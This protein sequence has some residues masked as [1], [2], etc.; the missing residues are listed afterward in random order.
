V[1]SAIAVT[2][3]W[4][5]IHSESF[6][7]EIS[8][9][10]SVMLTKKMGAELAFKRVE[11]GL[12][13]P[14]T[15]F[16]EVSLIKTH[17]QRFGAK[18]AIDELGVYFTYAS[19]IS[20]NL[21]IDEL[22]LKNGS[23]NVEIDEDPTT[24][25]IN[26][27]KLNQQEL[28]E[29]Y[30]H[31]YSQLPLHLNILKLTDVVTKINNVSFNAKSVMISPY[32]KEIRL[33][34]DI[35]KFHLD[36]PATDVSS[37][38]VL[39][40]F[41]KTTWNIDNLLISDLENNLNLSGN[42]T[43][44]SKSLEVNAEGE[45]AIQLESL[46]KY[47]I[48]IP[49]DAKDVQGR[50]SGKFL[51]Q[52]SLFDPNANIEMTI[53]NLKSQ[54]VNLE[55]V[56]VSLQ[57]KKDLILIKQAE[58][59]NKQEHYKTKDAGVVFDLRKKTI[60]NFKIP[61]EVVNAETNTFLF[62]IRD[63]L[64]TFKG[65]VTGKVNVLWD[66]R[67]I[68]FEILEKTVLK[69]FAL[70]MNNS[71]KDILVNNGFIIEGG[72]ITI[73]KNST[74][75]LDLNLTMPLSTLHAKGKIY[76]DRLDIEV[77]NSII[78]MKNFGP[79]SGVK[80]E[81]TG[82]VDLKIQGPMDDVHF[83]FDVKW[84]NFSVIDLHLG[85]VSAHF[86]FGLKNL[87][88]SIPKFEG[89]FNQ[90]KYSANGGLDF[91]D[92]SNMDL[93]LDFKETNFK[94]T[95]QMYALI[96][97]NMKNFPET[98][99]KF[100]TSYR[101]TGGFDLPAL[102][103]N[104]KIKGRDLKIFEEEAD[105]VN[106]DFSLKKEILK[107]EK[108]RIQKSRGEA[109]GNFTVNL[110]NNHMDLIGDGHGIKLSDF[111]HYRQTGL[112]YDADLIFDFNGS[113]TAEKFPSQ[114]KIKTTEAFID[115]MV[116]SPSKAQV[117][118]ENN[119]IITKLDALGSKVKSDI[120]VGMESKQVNIKTSVDSQDLRELLGVLSSHNMLDK[121][122][123][124]KLKAK[125]QAEFN[126][127]TSKLNRLVIDINNFSL[128]KG[129][130]DLKSIT[131]KSYASIENG[132][133]KKWDLRF[134][135]GED[136]FNS[137]GENIRPGL[138]TLSQEFSIKSNIFQLV[139]KFVDKASG[140]IKGN[141]KVDIGSDLKIS[142]FNLNARNNSLKF[143]KMPGIIN[144]FEFEIKKEQQA[145]V[146]KKIQGKYGDGE[147]K[148]L[149]NIL[150]Q[151]IFPQI[152]LE[153]KIDRST[154]PLFKR[155]SVL[156]SGSGTL[157]GV[158]PPY[159]LNGKF[160]LLHGEFLDD[161][162]E[163]SG[164][165]KVNLEEFKKYLP[166]K[167]S[168]ENRGFIALN[169][170][171][172]TANSPLLVK[173]NMAEIYLKG[174]GVVTGN[175]LDPEVNGRVDA[176]PTISKFK[177]KGHEFIINQGFV[178]LKDTGKVRNSDLKFV[179]ISRISDYDMKIDLS[180]SIE[181]LNIN[182]SSEPALAQEDLLSLLTLGVTSDM[183]KNLESGERKYVTTV[184]IGTLLVDQLKINEDLNSSLGLKLSVM[185]EFREDVTSL[186][187]GKSAVTDSSATKLKSSTKIK[188][189]K[190]ISKQVDVS[191]SSTVGGSLEQKQEVNVNYNFN[192]NWSLEGVY[193]VKPAEDTSTSTSTPNSVG[194]DL[195]YKWSF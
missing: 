95:Q 168:E 141:Y 151:G 140:K 27:K 28:Y 93:K 176:L 73:D 97:R 131:G 92:K 125:F 167:N 191:L 147:F 32:K 126:Y 115:N 44:P 24:P 104:G 192:K 105:F 48:E 114:V 173:N 159:M 17:T 94:D 122:L 194:A 81:G 69:N 65:T 153:Y 42:I 18:M 117:N 108:I 127:G 135:D 171:L 57:K 138:V 100:E 124:G 182:L 120:I 155:S 172:E 74:V 29:K 110:N 193:E 183:S 30:S 145:F 128:K 170:N 1:L 160:Q 175:P 116:A 41:E 174:A 86:D 144:D 179:G 142:E 77:A 181:K 34:L 89:Q 22:E 99:L 143:K 9:R 7:R 112:D 119:E 165:K 148:I 137:V 21:E 75:G 76:S 39:A 10:A 152:N 6:S 84:K 19:L 12:F 53:A 111:N 66:G 102:V 154:V 47:Y 78:D 2:A 60:L 85:D 70:K 178:E 26:W 101:V 45:Y 158:K 169:I 68:S 54:W 20:S 189:N 132:N 36:K 83:A 163:Y 11:F 187:Q 96:F 37:I 35:S 64:E 90:T 118:F 149:G 190:Q 71:K 15:R 133:I 50:L 51:V 150:F 58:A 63:V 177:F 103:I 46:S 109:N 62:I 43:T 113:G 31:I 156:A 52:G 13:P 79:I 164:D 121:N 67:N 38:K 180:G 139:S 162:S 56:K 14:S 5:F 186:V 61:V 166:E 136:F 188:V 80:L 55:S 59:F 123:L 33:K 107:F 8:R 184:G 16:K 185:P 106:M 23:M 25:E 195:K 157:Q 72:L 134:V 129:D 3:V 146:V 82:P 87:N 40:K 91:G 88:L 98:D 4:K 130:V 161:A 49:K